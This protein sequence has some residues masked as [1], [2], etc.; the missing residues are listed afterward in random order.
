MNNLSLYRLLSPSWRD[1]ATGWKTGVQFPAG[2]I[3]GFFLF[4]TASISA[5]GLTQL[6]LRE[7]IQKF[8]D[9][10]PG[11]KTANGTALCH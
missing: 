7:C 6:P 5:M 4:D 3:M 2:A 11:A 8:P 1:K 10:A 9:W